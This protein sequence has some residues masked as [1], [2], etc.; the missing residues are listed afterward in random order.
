MQKDIGIRVIA[1]SIPVI[2]DFTET[3]VSQALQNR[4]IVIKNGRSCREIADDKNLRIIC[5][6][7]AHI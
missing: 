4:D 6:I 2:F 1:T 5:E 7:R 3:A